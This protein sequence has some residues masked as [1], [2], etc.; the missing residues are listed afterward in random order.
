MGSKLGSVGLDGRG[1]GMG[2]LGRGGLVGSDADLWSYEF[3]GHGACVFGD[4][5][6]YVV[7][8]GCAPVSVCVCVSMCVLSGLL[9]EQTFSF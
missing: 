9:A 8:W 2:R 5:G 7:W 6:R 3:C 1:E 4:G